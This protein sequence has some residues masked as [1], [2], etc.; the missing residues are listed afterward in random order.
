MPCD[1]PLGFALIGPNRF[2]EPE[3]HEP[4]QLNASNFQK[5]E[6]VLKVFQSHISP[7]ISLWIFLG[8]ENRFL[9][10]FG[11]FDPIN[12]G[13]INSVFFWQILSAINWFYYYRYSD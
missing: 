11:K 5:Q 4:T 12:Q 7:Q 9:L 3:N 10:Q 13:V 6:K 2:Y 1:G 8:L